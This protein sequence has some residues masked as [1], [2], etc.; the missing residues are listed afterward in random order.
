MARSS[1]EVPP[2]YERFEIVTNRD[3]IDAPYSPFGLAV[4]VHE[5]DLEAWAHL[6]A[7][8]ADLRAGRTAAPRAASRPTP[9]WLPTTAPTL[10]PLARERK[11]RVVRGLVTF[12][13]SEHG[14]LRRGIG[15]LTE[16]PEADRLVHEDGFAFL[17]AVLSTSR[18]GTAGRGAR[19]SSSGAG[20]A[21][22]IPAGCSASRA[23]LPRRSASGPPSTGT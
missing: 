17:L 12:E 8:R 14:P 16:D 3:E 11:L 5:D 9:R 22:S 21:T 10:E 15:R 20:S 2:G 4:K 18:C 1:E 19:R 23:R 13:E 6:A 7:I